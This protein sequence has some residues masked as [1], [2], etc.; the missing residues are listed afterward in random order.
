M[1]WNCTH[2]NRW[3]NAVD[4][5]LADAATAKMRT[6]LTDRDSAWVD[7]REESIGWV[8]K[9]KAFTWLSE[10]DGWRHHY[11]ATCDSRD[12]RLVSEG[13]FDVTLHLN[14]NIP[15]GPKP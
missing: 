3:Q 8:E 10:R 12:V 9:G 6:I 7:L 11:V 1:K 5:M 13:N 15:A 14:E 4:V 2:I